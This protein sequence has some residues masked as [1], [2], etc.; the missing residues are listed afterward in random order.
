MRFTIYA[1]GGARGNPGPAGAGAAVLSEAGETLIEVSEFLGHA[2]NNFAEYTAVLRALEALA[3]YLGAGAKDAEV[4]VRMDSLL[5]VEQM[6]GNWKIKHPGLKP[7]WARVGA[8]A[9]LFKSVT[10]SHVPRA[11]NAHADRLANAAMDSGM[12]RI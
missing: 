10:F 8:L 1:D 7:L 11:K 9:G 12:G 4:S 5:V 2:T 6:S 3:D